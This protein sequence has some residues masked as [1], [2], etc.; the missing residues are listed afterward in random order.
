[1]GQVINFGCRLNACESEAISQ[2]VDQLGIIDFG[3]GNVFLRRIA[4]FFFEKPHE[5]MTA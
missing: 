1:M 4:G 2:F 3:N 5:V